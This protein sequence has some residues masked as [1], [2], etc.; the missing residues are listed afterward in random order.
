MKHRLVIPTVLS[1]IAIGVSAIELGACEHDRTDPPIDTLLPADI[2]SLP[3][4]L[5][6]GM[7]APEPDATVP[8]DTAP[9]DTPA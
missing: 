8:L 6:A 4:M 3:S 1:V 5:D 9:P 2:G 7:D